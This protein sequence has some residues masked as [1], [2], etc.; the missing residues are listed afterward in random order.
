M[1]CTLVPHPISE[2][3][4]TYC[5][6]QKFTFH[7]RKNNIQRKYIVCTR[8]MLFFCTLYNIIIIFFCIY[9]SNFHNS[10]T[11]F[12]SKEQWIPSSQ[13]LTADCHRFTRT[14]IYTPFFGNHCSRTQR[15]GKTEIYWTVCRETLGRMDR[16]T[17]TED[18]TLRMG[19][20]KGRKKIEME[21][22]KRR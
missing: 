8:Q 1:S 20:K 4:V 21:I 9:F 12:S 5:N 11:R 15:S 14:M 7:C 17:Y 22:E 10:F 16:T 19:I 2:T 3:A 18:S 6:K 13:F